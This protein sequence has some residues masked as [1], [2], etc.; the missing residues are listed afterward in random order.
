MPPYYLTVG[1]SDAHKNQW[2]A[3][4]LIIFQCHTYLFMTCI[5]VICIVALWCVKTMTLTFVYISLSDYANLTRITDRIC[6]V[7]N[8]VTLLHRF[9]IEVQFKDIYEL[10]AW[11]VCCGYRIYLYSVTKV[12]M[13][14]IWSLTPRKGWKKNKKT[15]MGNEKTKLIY[16][17]P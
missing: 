1:I 12:C 6:T 9:E 15:R 4:K 7:T 14:Y 13:S 11:S 3:G 8:A 10:Y 5:L 16:K 17:F 2:A